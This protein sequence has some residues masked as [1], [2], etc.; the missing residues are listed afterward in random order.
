V[1]IS[2]RSREREGKT[3]EASKAGFEVERSWPS[4]GLGCHEDG[5]GGDEQ[6]SGDSQK[7]G[8]H[9]ARS[10]TTAAEKNCLCGRG[11]AEREKTRW[12]VDQGKIVQKRPVEDYT[13]QP[14][15]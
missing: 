5:A 2:I 7:K 11:L 13:R 14:S 12:K 4:E 9:R 6:S 10:R 8:L 3:E 15:E 1:R